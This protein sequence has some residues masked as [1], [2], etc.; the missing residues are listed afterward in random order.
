[1]GLRILKEGEASERQSLVDLQPKLIHLMMV[2][3]PFCIS[4]GLTYNAKLLFVSC[5][6]QDERKKRTNELI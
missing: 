6:K 1:M 4:P 5:Y 2:F 3:S